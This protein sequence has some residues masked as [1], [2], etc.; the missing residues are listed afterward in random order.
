MNDL[1]DLC[2]K[3][4]LTKEGITGRSTKYILSRNKH[5]KTEINP[6]LGY[7]IDCDIII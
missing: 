4:L 1:T 5:E 3:G 2:N 7:R 6:K